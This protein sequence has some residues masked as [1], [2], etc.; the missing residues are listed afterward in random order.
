MNNIMLYD[1]I[2]L[3]VFCAAVFLFLYSHRKNLGREGWMYMYRT[4]LGLVKI[5]EFSKKYS[6]LL[7]ILKYP[8]VIVGFAL[9]A[10]M[11]YLLCKTVYIYV[12]FPQ[13]S[14][15]IKAPPVMPL[16][17]YFPQIFGVE[18]LMPPFYFAYFLI[19]LLIVAVVHEF[20]H[21]I[22]MRL[23]K[24]KIKSTG[25]AFLGPILGAFVEQDDKD[26]HKKK[27]FEQ[28]V[29]LG[30][31]VFANILFA[32]IFFLLLVLFFYASYSPAGYI[33]DNFAYSA[34]N[35]SGVSGIGNMSGGLTEIYAGNRTYLYP[36]N[37]SS[38]YTK[39]NASD[40][41]YILLYENAPAIK[42]NI[43]GIIV[44]IDSQ[45]VKTR[46]D[47]SFYLEDKKP[48]DLVLITTLNKDVLKNYSIVLAENPVN[49]TRGFVGIVS[50]PKQ[51]NGLIG[52]FVSKFTGFRDSSV[53]YEAN[54]S[55]DFAYYIYNL[56]WWIMMINLF[57]GL[58]NMLPLGILDG[59]RFFYLA[60]LSIVKDKNVAEKSYKYATR[61]IGLIFLAMI[62][63]W[64][65]SLL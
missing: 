55:P 49:S 16:I 63:A 56:I 11:I 8:I 17:P 20:S 33:F 15:I 60:I 21:G 38:F 36:G 39:L 10:T 37:S 25:F 52:K 58:F 42:N 18:S 46:T 30:A 7:H 47:V 22:Y 1:L 43:S 65:F 40:A 32:L 2:F 12:A 26:F 4:K 24:T 50:I 23:F 59:G 41:E 35:A 54:Y 51:S 31:G 57:V 53:Y 48:G 44:A 34:V 62:I 45:K 29:V 19:A 13:I 5:E 3:A 61:F 28:M 64:L 6:K 27:N 9:M 14:D